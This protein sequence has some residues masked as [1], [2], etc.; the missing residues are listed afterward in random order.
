M[1]LHLLVT[2]YAAVTAAAAAAD[3]DDDLLRNPLV[4]TY[5]WY[6]SQLQAKPGSCALSL[7]VGM[8]DAW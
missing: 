4:S 2:P 8:M 3:D 7:R 5:P 1:A 6:S